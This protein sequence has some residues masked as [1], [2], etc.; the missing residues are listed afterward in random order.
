MAPYFY[1]AP[2]LWKDIRLTSLQF[3]LAQSIPPLVKCADSILEQKLI[4]QKRFA[5]S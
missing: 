2:E 1:R 3:G 5:Q 4:N